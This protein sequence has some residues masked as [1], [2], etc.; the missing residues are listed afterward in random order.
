M[1]DA[2]YTCF[3]GIDIAAD[4]F[5]MAWRTADATCKKAMTCKQ[6]P[7]GFRALVR[8]LPKSHVVEHTLIL[9]EATSTYWIP[10][11]THLY[12]LGYAVCVVNPLRAHGFARTMLQRSKTDTID[13][14]M[15]A[16]MAE[17]FRFDLW[18]PPPQIY[19]ELRQRLDQRA[20]LV[21]I[22]TQEKNRLH[23]L[24]RRQPAISAVLK[25]TKDFITYL[26]KQIAEIDK[27]IKQV[28]HTDEA[29]AT[30]ATCL[31][32]IPG[33]GKTLTAMLLVT[34]LNFTTCTSA[35]QLVSYAGL[36]PREFQSGKSIH[37]RPYIGHAGNT[38]LRRMLYMGAMSAIR[39]NM[40]LKAFYERLLANGKHKKVALCAVARKLLCMAFGVVKHQTN[41]DPNYENLKTV[42]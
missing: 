11:A 42:A 32:S 36:A 25:R 23:A 28:L 5:S 26:D 9:M 31:M 40:P 34:T 4:T 14:R 20:H 21:H 15:L 35:K 22:R 39:H 10:L 38:N 7:S 2:A 19:E 13:A 27:E 16:Q 6:T 29:W 3:V 1:N 37:R 30:S 12:D 24:K 33:I 8:N 17:K 18:S 41:F